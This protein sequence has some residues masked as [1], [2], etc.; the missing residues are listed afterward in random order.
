MDSIL[1]FLATIPPAATL[2]AWVAWLT[3]NYQV[4]KLLG[5]DGLRATPGVSKAFS[6]KG[7]ALFTTVELLRALVEM[8]ALGS[9]R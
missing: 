4:A 5:V 1:I 7:W 6:L 2:A 8:L 3:F 9:S